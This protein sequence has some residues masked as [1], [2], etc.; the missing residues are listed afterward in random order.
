M[1]P[2]KLSHAVG[3]DDFPFPREHRGDVSVVGAVYAGAR[4]EGVL[5]GE[6]R[7]DGRN[8]TEVLARLV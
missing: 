1:K 2:S 6:I 4:L 3:V 7:R 5:R 8:S